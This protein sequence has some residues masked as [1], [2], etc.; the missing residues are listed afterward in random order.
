[1]STISMRYDR[2][3]GVV[4][5]GGEVD[6]PSWEAVNEAIRRLDAVT[7]TLVTI[8]FPDERHL[9]VGGGAGRY[10]VYATFDNRDFWNLLGVEGGD[11]MVL[12]SAGGQEGDYRAAQIVG[13]D[14]ALAAARTFLI[15]QR[16]E[17]S[18]RWEQQA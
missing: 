15:E 12:L 5:G 10:V 7:Y 13:L 2:W 18:L 16:L 14:E 3:D 8:G 6:E 1:M 11:Q 4:D 17:S 9:A